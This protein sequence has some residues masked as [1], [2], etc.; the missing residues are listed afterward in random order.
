MKKKKTKTEPQKKDQ[1]ETSG[2]PVEKF[3]TATQVLEKLQ[4]AA[5]QI[6]ALVENT[7]D[8]RILHPQNNEFID[9]AVD[10]LQLIRN[11]LHDSDDS[12][13]ELIA[14]AISPIID[15]TRE[16]LAE[17][18]R[19]AA[20]RSPELARKLK[21]PEFE[22]PV[23]Y[24]DSLQSFVKLIEKRDEFIARMKHV[25]PESRA[26]YQ[27]M[28]A[29]MDTIINEGEEAFAVEYERFQKRK[30]YEDGF[31]KLLKT[32]SKKELAEL[33]KELKKNPTHNGVLERILREEF[34]E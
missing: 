9:S 21:P 27:M 32:G 16:R 20:E 12:D 15:R 30:Q 10:S 7:T 31:R 34:P 24:N 33:R 28:I 23:W 1:T 11:R 29:E 6:V 22:M 2:E 3:T 18:R 14:N 17:I 26:E 19:E 13:R 5:D 25:L 4:E 8:E